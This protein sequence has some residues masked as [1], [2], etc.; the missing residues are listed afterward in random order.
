M[1]EV[2]IECPR[3]YDGSDPRLEDQSC[4]V[5]WAERTVN[6]TS[7]DWSGQH[8]NL[9]R[10]LVFHPNWKKVKDELRGTK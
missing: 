2:I 5:C 3:C 9:I 10:H 8:K 1:S 4:L 6:L 7:E